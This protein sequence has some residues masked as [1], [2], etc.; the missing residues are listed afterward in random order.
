MRGSACGSRII[1]NCIG[2]GSLVN[3]IFILNYELENLDNQTTNYFNKKHC[4]T[5]LS[6]QNLRF[7]INKNLTFMLSTN[8]LYGEAA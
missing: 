4:I 8:A 6:L 5:S 2:K 3:T 1:K 7:L